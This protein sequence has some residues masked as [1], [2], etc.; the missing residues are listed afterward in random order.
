MSDL[1]ITEI[2]MAEQIHRTH[3]FDGLS[4][5]K[6]KKHPEI[7]Y[8][9]ELAQESSDLQEMLNTSTPSED[10][11]SSIRCLGIEEIERRA[12]VAY[13]RLLS[14]IDWVTTLLA[15]AGWEWSVRDGILAIS[16]PLITVKT[17]KEEP[18]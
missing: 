7:I 10:M 8:Y 18:A 12:E 11:L 3:A 9:Q 5:K 1:S 6:I 14:Q 2:L 4:L 16:V 17:T 13:D 15:T